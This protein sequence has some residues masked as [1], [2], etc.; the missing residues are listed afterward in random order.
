LDFDVISAVD[1]EKK[2]A[3]EIERKGLSD[4]L[5]KRSNLRKALRT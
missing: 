4:F 1:N 3:R 5:L 2:A